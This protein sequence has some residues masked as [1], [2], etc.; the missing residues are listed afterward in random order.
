[1]CTYY[2]LYEASSDQSII[3]MMVSLDTLENHQF[4]ILFKVDTSFC[5]FWPVRLCE[6]GIESSQHFSFQSFNNLVHEHIKMFLQPAYNYIQIFQQPAY[7][8]KQIFQQPAY[9]YVQM[10]LGLAFGHVSSRSP[11]ILSPPIA[12]IIMIFTITKIIVTADCNHYHLIGTSGCSDALLVLSEG[13]EK[14]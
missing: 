14:E 1:M 3:I 2:A 9:N 5:A 7:N 13:S 8:Y 12:I 6:S 4:E 10:A 11:N